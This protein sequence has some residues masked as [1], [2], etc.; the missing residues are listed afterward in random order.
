MTRA[1]KIL[2]LLR[3]RPMTFEELQQASGAEAAIVRNTLSDLKRSGYTEAIPTTYRA[4]EKA[5]DGEPPKIEWK[6]FKARQGGSENQ[7]K[8]KLGQRRAASEGIVAS[9]MRNVPT[10]VFNLGAQI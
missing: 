2:S 7:K 10:S 9:A 8:P 6:A 4:T 3:E 5:A 1:E